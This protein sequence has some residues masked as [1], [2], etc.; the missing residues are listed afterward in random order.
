MGMIYNGT[1]YSTAHI[2]GQVESDDRGT[3]AGTHTVHA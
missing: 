2:L 3:N 1:V